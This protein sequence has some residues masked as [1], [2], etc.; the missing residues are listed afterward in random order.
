MPCNPPELKGDRQ[1][2]GEL[3]GG[4]LSSNPPSLVVHGDKTISH[5]SPLSQ[6]STGFSSWPPPRRAQLQASVSVK[7]I[8]CNFKM[9]ALGQSD[10]TGST[11]CHLASAVQCHPV[12]GST[13]AGSWGHAYVAFT[14]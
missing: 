3:P 1:P 7:L 4:S 10:P 9:A 8:A 5:P 13:E 2:C 6:F 11:T 14:F 12:W